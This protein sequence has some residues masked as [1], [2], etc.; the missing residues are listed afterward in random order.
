MSCWKAEE[1]QEINISHHVPSVIMLKY[2]TLEMNLL[3][4]QADT[5]NMYPVGQLQKELKYVRI[6][7]I[8]VRIYAELLHHP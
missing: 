7:W 8:H 1:T 5:I 4:H 2:E 3:F 6:P